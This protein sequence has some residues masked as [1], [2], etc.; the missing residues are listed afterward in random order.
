MMHTMHALGWTTKHSTVAAA[1]LAT[2]P[3]NHCFQPRERGVALRA[4]LVDVL[5]QS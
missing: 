3:A 2:Y 5:V 4:R 1:N